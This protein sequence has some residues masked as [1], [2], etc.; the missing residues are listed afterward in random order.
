MPP[1]SAGIVKAGGNGDGV[2]DAVV[3]LVLLLFFSS[4]GLLSV[5]VNGRN[6]FL[7]LDITGEVDW[8]QKMIF[9]YAS[10]AEET[11]AQIVSFCGHDS[12]PWDLSAAQLSE[13]L[14]DSKDEE[15]VSM[16]FVDKVEGGI[17]GGT[18][19]TA[20]LAMNRSGKGTNYDFV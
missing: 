10:V 1:S 7:L 13:A 12:V 18:L 11:G 17:S 15:L 2:I 20:C 19:A 3:S 8:S 5:F 4:F 16:D 14:K 9:K 6:D